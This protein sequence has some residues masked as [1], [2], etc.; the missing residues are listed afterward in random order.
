[1]ETKSELAKAIIAVMNEVAGIEKS[2]TVGTGNSSYKGVSD[3]D[4][5]RIIGNAMAKNGLCILPLGVDS[6]SKIDRWEEVDQY[7]KSVPKDM[8]TKQSVF[9]EVETKYLLL[10]TSGESQSI[11]GYGHGVDSQDK[12]AGKATTYALKNALLYTFMIPTG[13]IDDTDKTHSSEYDKVLT[14]IPPFPKLK[15]NG[16]EAVQ[17][18]NLLKVAIAETGIAKDSARLKQIW[19]AYPMFHQDATFKATLNAKKLEIN[20]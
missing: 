19:E 15:A 20:K 16:G 18:A 2:L 7:S 13:D 1:M 12:S 4:V 9:V 6:K 8:K 10:H 17:M 14:N 11:A 5:K 3:K